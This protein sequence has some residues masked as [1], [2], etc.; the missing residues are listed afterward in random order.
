[1]VFYPALRLCF[2]TCGDAD[3]HRRCDPPLVGV[4]LSSFKR[5]ACGGGANLRDDMR[6]P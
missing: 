3:D 4:G 1:M 5:Y 6:V 2:D